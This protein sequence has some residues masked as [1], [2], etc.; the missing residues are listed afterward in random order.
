M[1]REILNNNDIF[2]INKIINNSNE[3]TESDID[4][5]PSD[6]NIPSIK[7]QKKIKKKI[8]KEHQISNQLPIVK[9]D[10]D[11]Q[12]EKQKNKRKQIKLKKIKS[13]KKK[14]FNNI[15]NIE[16]SKGDKNDNIDDNFF[17]SS[18]FIPIE[19][20]DKYNNNESMIKFENENDNDIVYI[21][22]NGKDIYDERNKE[23]YNEIEIEIEK[24]NDTENELNNLNW[25]EIKENNYTPKNIIF[26]RK[27]I[28][29]IP[30]DLT[31]PIDYFNL[32]FSDVIMNKI[33]ESINQYAKQLSKKKKK[34]K[35]I[36]TIDLTILKCFI[37]VYIAMGIVRKNTIDEY[38]NNQSNIYSTPGISELFD[39]DLFTEIYSIIGLFQDFFN[40]N[41]FD[42]NSFLNLFNENCQKFYSPSQ[43]LTIDKS[44]IT[45]NCNSLQKTFKLFLLKESKSKYVLNCLINVGKNT[46]NYYSH[47]HLINYLTKT[48]QNQGYILYIDKYFTSL[49]LLSMLPSIGIYFVGLINEDKIKLAVKEKK[50][51]LNNKDNIIYL[52]S[53]NDILLTIFQSYKNFFIVSNCL[54]NKNIKQKIMNI[55]V[56]NKTINIRNE[57]KY[58]KIK[59]FPYPYIQYRKNKIENKF[60]HILPYNYFVHKSKCLPTK[61]FFYFLEI[62]INN[63]NILYNKNSICK[64]LSSLSFRRSLIH[65]L[66]INYK[67]QK[68][69]FLEDKKKKNEN[70][71]LNNVKIDYMPYIENDCRLEYSLKR[72]DCLLHKLNKIRKRTSWKCKVCQISICGECYDIHRHHRYL[73]L[74]KL[75]NK[76]NNS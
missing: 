33:V 30:N 65:D 57:Q 16:S 47:Y 74:N 23:K 11:E 48:Y 71:I 39:K 12:L 2:D 70:E 18:F 22:E 35:K 58:S 62:A 59:T 46:N 49:E 73:I 76:N 44:I 66:I 68:K 37:G 17:S 13:K 64:K 45:H 15:N 63:S 21:K 67:T 3:E 7:K 5:V 20:L 24:G 42:D 53:N 54:T 43:D 51:I 29:P 55:K 32:I 50:I 14:S 31:K 75:L 34:K 72:K 60:N 28:E 69:Y 8:K 6:L 19:N 38:W 26:S 27:N 9:L 61:F 4:F 56:D 36:I 52:Q 10:N 1:L 41:Q 40:L 25:K